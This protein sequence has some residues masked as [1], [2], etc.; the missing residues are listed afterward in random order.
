MLEAQTKAKA[1]ADWL[2]GEREAA[3]EIMAGL[4]AGAFR[5]LRLDA[6]EVMPQMPWLAAGGYGEDRALYTSPIFAGD[7]EPRTVHLGLDI[8]A[9]A[10]TAV[11][12]PLA[13]RVHSFRDNANPLD[14]GPTI[15][16]EH[17][18]ASSGFGILVFYT[19]YGHLA[20]ESLEGLFAGK[21]FAAGE[22]LGWLGAVG[23]NGGWPPHLHVQVVLDLMEFEGDFP[24]VARRS[25]SARWLENCPDPGPLLGFV[26]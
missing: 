12:A 22:R 13:G 21:A 15:I 5:P 19:L 8:F 4:H 6:V 14:Y 16:L 1:Y 10:G 9:P 26:V 24:G 20:R 18:F 2:G 11:F 3:A 25:E 7:G 17:A 23:V